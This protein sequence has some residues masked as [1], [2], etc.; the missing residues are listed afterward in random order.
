MRAAQSV[1]P[2]NNSAADSSDDDR[3]HRLEEGTL[4]GALFPM[5]IDGWD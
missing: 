1:S 2:A 3:E 5:P 4:D